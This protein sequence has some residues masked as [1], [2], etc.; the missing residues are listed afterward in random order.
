MANLWEDTIN[1]SRIKMVG[2]DEDVL[3]FIV[4]GG[5]FDGVEYEI[6][7]KTLKI[8][9]IDNIPVINYD[10]TVIKGWDTSLQKRIK[11]HFEEIVGNTLANAFMKG[12]SNTT[13][14]I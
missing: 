10:I 11:A 14:S 6:D 4:Y 1:N 7:K 2:F 5:L 8:D 3:N 12:V 13:D 9:K